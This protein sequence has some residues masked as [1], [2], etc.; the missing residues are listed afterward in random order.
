MAT[1]LASITETVKKFIDI[2]SDVVVWHRP[3]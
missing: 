1:T 2:G 3:V